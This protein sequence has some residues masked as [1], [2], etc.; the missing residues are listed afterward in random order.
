LASYRLEAS[1]FIS[2]ITGTI[3]ILILLLSFVAL[4]YLAGWC[5]NSTLTININ[6]ENIIVLKI[7]L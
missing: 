4:V 1:R 3:I 2:S 5:I 7:S 6:E